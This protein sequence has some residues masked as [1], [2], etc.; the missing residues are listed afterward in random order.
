MGF[1]YRRGVAIVTGASSGIGRAIALDLAARGTNVVLVARR[2]NGDPSRRRLQ[3][4]EVRPR[5]LER[6]AGGGSPRLRGGNP[7]DHGRARAHPIRAKAPGASFV[8]RTT[9]SP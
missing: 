3:R 2:P 6:G 1:D 8:P 5:W 9:R 7:P 4:D